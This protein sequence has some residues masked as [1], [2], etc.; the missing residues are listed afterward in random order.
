MTTLHQSPILNYLGL[1]FGFLGFSFIIYGYLA[2]STTL[3]TIGIFTSF[4]AGGML[5]L[6]KNP[7]E[8]DD[9]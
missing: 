1:L 4:L 7:P 8:S 9:H 3:F 5:L 2:P 6:K